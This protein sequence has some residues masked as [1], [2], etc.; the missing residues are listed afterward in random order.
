MSLSAVA[1]GQAAVNTAG[2]NTIS[3][4]PASNCTAGALLILCVAYDNQGAA[5]IDQFSAITDTKGNTWTLRINSLNNPGIGAGVAG[6]IFTTRQNG[7]TLLTTDTITVSLGGIT[8][9]A[10]AW[11]LT[12]AK[13]TTGIAEYVTGGQATDAL[14][15][16]TITSAS[17]AINDMIIGCFGREG[18]DAVTTPD[19]D[20]LNGSW[21]AQQAAGIGTTTAGM[22][23]CTQTKVVT[24][25]GAQTYNVTFGAARDNVKMWVEIR[26]RTIVNDS[27]DGTSL[28]I[29]FT[30]INAIISVNARV[31]ASTLATG[32]TANSAGITISANVIATTLVIGL[33]ANNAIISINAKVNAATL[34]VGLTANNAAT[35]IS[36]NVI[37]TTLAVGLSAS[38][39]LIVVTRPTDMSVLAIGYT[40]NNITVPIQANLN[41]STLAVGLT[42]NNAGITAAHPTDMSSAALGYTANNAGVTVA[43]PFNAT[44]TPIGY[45]TNNGEVAVTRPLNVTSAAIGYA[46]NNADITSRYVFN[47]TDTPIGYAAGGGYVGAV[48]DMPTLSFALGFTPYNADFDWIVGAVHDAVNAL[49]LEIGFSGF[50][51]LLPVARNIIAGTANVGF[52]ADTGTFGVTLKTD[53]ITASLGFN[54]E[55]ANITVVRTILALADALGFTGYGENAFYL[56]SIIAQNV[57]L[58]FTPYTASFPGS[59]SIDVVTCE[60]VE[61]GLTTYNA[62]VFAVR[63]VVAQHAGIG[64]TMEQA[65]FIAAIITQGIT[66]TLGFTSYDAELGAIDP[67]HTGMIREYSALMLKRLTT[68]EIAKPHDVTRNVIRRV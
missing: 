56:R 2:Q 19:A 20:T 61:L 17:I 13:P 36:A 4:V 50:T 24:A 49:T 63:E 10:R 7:G 28:A 48:R 5:G 67:H 45:T 62:L 40:A 11:T 6:R 1:R 47:A 25:A 29:G 51:A 32:L 66:G 60:S 14:A 30:A 53:A 35:T 43:R 31:N 55:N 37:A 23:I 18:N 34:A 9:V 38:N 57:G 33:T 41:A 68:P 21:T 52:S 39:A 64:I 59:S 44:D 46:A 16:P 15:T 27:V 8:T 3:V 26:E 42:S 22:Q 58:G 54:A 65:E 12:E